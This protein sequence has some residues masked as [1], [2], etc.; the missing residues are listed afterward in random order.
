MKPSSD[1][2]TAARK[3]AVRFADATTVL[4]ALSASQPETW[5]QASD[6]SDFL[7][8]RR[9]ALSGLLQALV[10]HDMIHAADFVGIEQQVSQEQFIA[11]KLLCMQYVQLVVCRQYMKDD[12]HEIFAAAKG[13]TAESGQQAHM[14]A[15]AAW[16]GD[17]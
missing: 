5:Y 17:C 9:V 2:T 14:R 10:K 13:F 7:Q 11:R 6:Y 8:D 16:N 15:M 1:V 3:K 4:P 12:V